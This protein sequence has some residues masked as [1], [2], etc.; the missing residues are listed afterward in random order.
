M[1]LSL[2][3]ALSWLALAN[4]IGMFPSRYAHWPQAYALISVG[5]P[6]LGFVFVQNGV[7]IGSAVLLGA[8]S[9][10][11]WPLRYFGRWLRAQFSS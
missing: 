10:L 7:W 1:N 9:V 4:V 11:R 8:A 2:I 5:L 3:L 6:I